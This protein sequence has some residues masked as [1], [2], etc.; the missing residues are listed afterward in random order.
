MAT[1][2]VVFKNGKGSLNAKV[3]RSGTVVDA[4]STTKTGSL[5]LQMQSGDVISIGGACTGNATITVD[6]ATTP[7][8]PIVDPAGPIN[9]MLIV[10]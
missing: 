7:D 1:L 5:N 2:N 9:H 4:G 10:S 6:V 8:T 3:Y